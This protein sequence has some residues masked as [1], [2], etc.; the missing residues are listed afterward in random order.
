MRLDVALVQQKLI[1]TRTKAKA[2]IEAGLVFYQWQPVTKPSQEIQD[3]D[4]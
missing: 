4:I 2:A 1:E 3:L